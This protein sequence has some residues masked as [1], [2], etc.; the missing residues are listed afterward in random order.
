MSKLVFI[1]R[2]KK[3]I[4]NLLKEIG[5][6]KYECALKDVGL[7]ESKPITLEGFYVQ[8]EVKTQKVSLYH[9]Y[10]SRV[11][12]F[13]MDVLGFWAVPTF[14]WERVRKEIES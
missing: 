6:E 14:G 8:Y 11:S 9:R 12:F 1:N 5:K 7:F 13:I 3:Q 10:P 2:D 4:R